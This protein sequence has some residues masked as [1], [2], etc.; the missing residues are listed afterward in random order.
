MAV[1]CPVLSLFPSNKILG[2]WPFE[3]TCNAN[4]IV[5]ITRSNSVD[6]SDAYYL[7]QLCLDR[8]VPATSNMD[9]RE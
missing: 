4:P 2:L 8:H 9:P 1:V 6:H 5:G 3:K 7:S